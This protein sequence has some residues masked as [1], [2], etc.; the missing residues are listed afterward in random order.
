MVVVNSNK[1]M[2][3]CFSLSLSRHTETY[4]CSVVVGQDLVAR[5]GVSSM[6]H[7]K[8]QVLRLIRD[9]TKPKVNQKFI[10]HFVCDI[11]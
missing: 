11:S 7:L 3:W 9:S 6:E 5:L 4:V 1:C 8:V 2:S 10:N